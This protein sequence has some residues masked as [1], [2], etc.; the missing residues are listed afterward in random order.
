MPEK[1]ILLENEPLLM[2]ALERALKRLDL[3]LYKAYSCEQARTLLNEHEDVA[4]FVTD[5]YLD[6][7]ETSQE[8][9][10]WTHVR[11]PSCR[12]V[13]MS[14]RDQQNID[15][16]DTLYECFIAKP[17]SVLD[18]RHIVAEQIELFAASR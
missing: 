13:L 2:R 12:C 17:F 18:F 8:L 6:A 11:R 14:G 1:L 5:Y 15:L 7:G 10:E 4:V 3:A 9:L 16:N